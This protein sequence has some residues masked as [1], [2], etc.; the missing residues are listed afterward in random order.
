MSK[1]DIFQV[2]S[3]LN[4]IYKI[5][6]DYKNEDKIDMIDYIWSCLIMIWPIFK[7]FVHFK[8][9]KIPDAQHTARPNLICSRDQMA[10][11]VLSSVQALENL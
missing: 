10:K 8:V 4:S 11:S 2:R 5:N 9:L 1:I 7:N 6:K 3:F